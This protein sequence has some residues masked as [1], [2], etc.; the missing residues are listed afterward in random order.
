MFHNLSNEFTTPLNR[1]LTA[2]SPETALE[3]L[4][5]LF[6]SPVPSAFVSGSPH[7]SP[8]D[9][10]RRAMNTLGV[11]GGSGTRSV[12]GSLSLSGEGQFQ[13]EYDFS[14]AGFGPD[15]D[16]FQYSYFYDEV[17]RLPCVF[18][19]CAVVQ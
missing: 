2:E 14:R 18:V 5:P 7:H 12:P 15:S 19:P 10:T 1:G 11:R 13:Y 6:G 9:D 4:A 3:E 16:L 17:R 8:D